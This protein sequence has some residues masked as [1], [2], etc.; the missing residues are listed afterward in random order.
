MPPHDYPIPTASQ[1]LLSEKWCCQSSVDHPPT[2]PP[3]ADAANQDIRCQVLLQDG[4]Q[5]PP[6]LWVSHP[7]TI[8]YG[9]HNMQQALPHRAAAAA[10]A[11]AAVAGDAAAAAVPGAAIATG[12]LRLQ[13]L[14]GVF[15]DRLQKH[16]SNSSSSSSSR[17]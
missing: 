5:Q 12:Q 1:A 14:A 11:A 2:L 15:H 9:P 7:A 6:V 4:T 10:A 16:S 3:K 17:H 8:V 13:I